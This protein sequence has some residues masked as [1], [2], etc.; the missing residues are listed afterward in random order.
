MFVVPLIYVLTPWLDFADYHLPPWA[1]WIGV[2]IFALAIW[3][4]W[5]SHA[6][7]ARSWSPRLEILE[8]HTLVT[9]GVFRYIRHPMY[10]AHLL[11]GIA[12]VFLLQNWIAGFSMLVTWLPGYFYRIPVEELMMVEHFGDEY[13]D[14]MKGTGRVFPKLWR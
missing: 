8:G 3:L 9:H 11:W 12:Q 6:D 1:G 13:R 10:A 4:L 7:L 14:Y 2:A 5:R